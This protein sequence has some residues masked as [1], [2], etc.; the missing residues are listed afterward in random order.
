[1]LGNSRWPEVLPRPGNQSLPRVESVSPWFEIYQVNHATFAFLEPHHYEEVIAYLIIGADRAVLFDTGMGIANI[2]AEV[3]RL[4]HLP[5][6]VINSHSHYDHIGGNHHFDEV[7]AF[8]EAS[9]IARIE[10]GY[11]PAECQEFMVPGAYLDLPAGFDLAT[12]HIQPSHVTRRL[13]PLETINLGQRDLV[14]HHTPGETPGSI[15]L[16]DLRD[17]ILF[18]GDTFYPGTLWVH[19]AEAD[20]E[21]YRRSLKDLVGLL[22]QVNHLC[23]AHNEA[24]VAKE[25]LNNAVAGFEQIAAGGMVA[26]VQGEV[27]IYRFEGFSVALPY[28]LIKEE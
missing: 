2:Q 17:G 23:P 9:E 6:V 4:T 18:T 25:M 14:V 28:R 27:Q 7:W 10:R 1:M 22:P 24:Y 19:Q 8:D 13:H 16:F 12:Y 21:Q 15:C 5:I 20:F 11:S 26:E 3:G